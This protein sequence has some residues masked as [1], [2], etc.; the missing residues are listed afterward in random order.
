VPGLA[1]YGV[2]EK[3]L[4]GIVAKAAASSSMKG[5]PIALTEAELMAVLAEAR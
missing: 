1:V 5:N 2:G 3:D 4:S